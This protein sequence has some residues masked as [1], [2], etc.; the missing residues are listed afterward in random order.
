TSFFLPNS[1]ES[2]VEMLFA[3]LGNEFQFEV[4]KKLSYAS[5]WILGSRIQCE[6]ICGSIHVGHRIFYKSWVLEGQFLFFKM[7][8]ERGC[9]SP[10]YVWLVVFS[11]SVEELWLLHLQF[12]IMH[13]FDSLIERLFAHADCSLPCLWFR[14]FSTRRW[15]IV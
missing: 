5:L 6:L 4:K 9:P 13:W 11:F 1:L 15:D 8:F 3:G 14:R 12:S 2:L 10:K 7:I